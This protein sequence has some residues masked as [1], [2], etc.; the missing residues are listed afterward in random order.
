L[1]RIRAEDPEEPMWHGVD[2][3]EE[4]DGAVELTFHES[5]DP[6]LRPADPV[7]VACVL[8]RREGDG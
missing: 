2:S 1:D 6:A 7:E 5:E 4:R 8:Y 3:V